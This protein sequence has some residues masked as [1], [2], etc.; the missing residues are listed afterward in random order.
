MKVEYDSLIK[1]STWDLVERPTSKKILS[2]KWVFKLKRNQDGSINKYKA[3]LVA[4]GC[5]QKEGIDYDEV[6][7]PVARY[8]TLLATDLIS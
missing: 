2:N 5:E 1:N 6:F 7:V 4:R 3:R 8:D